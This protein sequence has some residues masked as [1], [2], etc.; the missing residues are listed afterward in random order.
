MSRQQLRELLQRVDTLP[1][2]ELAAAL[3]EACAL[4]DRAFARLA[5]ADQ[6]ADAAKEAVSFGVGERLNNAVSAYIVFT[7]WEEG[8]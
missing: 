8:K 5:L 1:R 6:L 4:L 3:L 7:V 2:E